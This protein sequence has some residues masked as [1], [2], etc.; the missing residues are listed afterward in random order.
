MK[1]IGAAAWMAMVVSSMFGT[2]VAAV[3]AEEP[4]VDYLVP[5]AAAPGQSLELAFHGSHLASPKGVW[6]NIP[7]AEVKL[8]PVSKKAAG[9]KVSH[10]RI[11]IPSSTPLGYY[12]IRLATAGGISNLRLVAVDDLP[13][14]AESADNKTRQSAQE[15]NLPVAL[16]GTAEAESYDYFRFRAERGQRLSVAV[17]ARRLGSPMDPVI[18]LLDSQGQLERELAYSDDE[19]AIGA[20]CRFVHTFAN[21]GNY[22]LE[23]RDI[24]YL[25]GVDYR[26]RLRLGDFPLATATFPLGVQRGAKCQLKIIGTDLAPLAPLSVSAPVDGAAPFL[27]LAAHYPNGQGSTPLVAIADSQGE[28]VEFEPNNSLETASPIELIGAVSGRFDVPHDRDYFQFTAKKGDHWLLAGRTRA[29]GL[30][31]DLFLRLYDAAGKQLA[32]VEDTAGD[33]GTID[34]KFAADGIYKLMV[35]DLLNRGG[36]EQAYRIEFSRYEPGFSLS[37]DADKAGV[38]KGGVLAVRVTAVRRGYK[39]PIELGLSGAGLPFDTKQAKS[40]AGKKDILFVVPLAE[41]AVP[42][43]YGL[44]QVVGRAKIDGKEFSAVASTAK[45]LR[46][47]LSGLATLPPDLDGWVAYGIGP[48]APDFFQLKPESTTISYLQLIGTARLKLKATRVGKFAD[49]IALAIEGLPPGITA[50]A[51]PIGKGKTDAV[52]EFTGPRAL[53]EGDYPLRVVGRATFENQPG[54]AVLD[55]LVLRVSRPLAVEATVAGKL[56]RGGKQ[57]VRIHVARAADDRQPIQLAWQGLPAGLHGED[58]IV[59]PADQADLET[60]LSAQADAPTGPLVCRL[61][62]TTKIQDQTISLGSDP[63]QLE[64]AGK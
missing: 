38:P 28:Q 2:S 30:P 50:K 5:A 31:T 40:T 48:V 36:A 51:D 55:Q 45:A 4:K 1:R 43:S 61:L 16:E 27:R 49:A 22:L 10:W 37:V 25:G 52:I 24:R 17:V 39:G 56:V 34:H 23:L 54:K 58:K 63:I 3:A 15:L 26:Y 14:L 42:G 8:V 20:D 60:T 33:E 64:V 59:I 32:E 21:A 7:G 6:T 12:G 57:K 53:A 29:L 18:R 9:D 44:L 13:T 46:T 62:A 41:S 11:T 35:E 47:T 19:E